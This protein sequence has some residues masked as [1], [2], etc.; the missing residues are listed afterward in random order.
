MTIDLG[1]EFKRMAEEFEIE[2]KDVL[3]SVRTMIRSMWGDSV[4]KQEFLNRASVMVKNTNTRSMKRFPLVR[5]YECAICGELF[6]ATSIELDHIKDE[7][8][9]TSYDHINDFI[10]SIVLTSPDNLQILCKDKKTK[11]DG[12]THFGCH[13]IK[14]YASRYGLTFEQARIKKEFINICKKNDK[15]LDKLKEFGVTLIPKTKKAQ[16]ELLEKLMLGE[17]DE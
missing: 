6:G 13:G 2:D 10:K 7:N 5:R 8:T 16:K 9:L 14:T 12:V 1:K 4:F 15:V 11:K 3:L 17:I